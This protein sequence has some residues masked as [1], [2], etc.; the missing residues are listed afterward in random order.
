[1]AF[2]N[3]LRRAG[4]LLLP[5]S[6]FASPFRFGPCITCC[7]EALVDCNYCK[8][9]KAPEQWIVT[10]CD[11]PVV[12]SGGVTIDI[13]G[14]Y[15]L[16]GNGTCNWC[17]VLPYCGGSGC[18]GLVP[19]CLK[20]LDNYRVVV[21]YA[22]AI[23]GYSGYWC[24][25]SHRWQAYFQGDEIVDGKVD[26]LA[27]SGK[28]LT[29]AS[30]GLKCHITAYPHAAPPADMFECTDKVLYA[31]GYLDGPNYSISGIAPGP[32]AIEVTID[33]QSYTLSRTCYECVDYYNFGYSPMWAYQGLGDIIPW[34]TPPSCNCSAGQPPR[35]RTGL[36]I[37]ITPSG[38]GWAI[39]IVYCCW[40]DE[41]HTDINVHWF[42]Y[43]DNSAAP[44][45]RLPF[46][47]EGICGLNTAGEL[48][49]RYSSQNCLGSGAPDWNGKR[50]T[51]R[52]IGGA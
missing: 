16:P 1:M 30:T 39:S 40:R 12:V 47:C 46:P 29:E 43:Q 36:R 8:D 28:E 48:I 10:I 5:S 3:C 38:S 4:G 32:A 44:E 23:S 41:T 37:E 27:V 18:T 45:D 20:L 21:E 35:I 13:N 42:H 52:A 25:H 11:A 2:D 9:G 24:G 50:C 6:S 33:G 26:C 49:Y 14:T 19:L 31:F 22:E 15:Y 34:I 51:V 17:R 7:E